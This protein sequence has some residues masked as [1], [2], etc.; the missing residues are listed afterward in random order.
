MVGLAETSLEPWGRNDDEGL[1]SN[2]DSS[3]PQPKRALSDTRVFERE[4]RASAPHSVARAF[5]R[6]SHVSTTRVCV[7]VCACARSCV[8][9]ARVE[10]AVRVFAVHSVDCLAASVEDRSGVDALTVV[11]RR[12]D[13]DESRV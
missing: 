12:V 11:R 9:L 6:A 1:I 2:H 4:R 3:K 10:D 8:V 13:D 7:S 5:G